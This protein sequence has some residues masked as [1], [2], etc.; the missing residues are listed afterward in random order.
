MTEGTP[1]YRCYRCGKVLW[2]WECP[3][4]KVPMSH[5]MDGGVFIPDYTPF[6]LRPH[7]AYV[8]NLSNIS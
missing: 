5:D 8:V 7:E 4:G 3:N 1:K 2:V 6:L